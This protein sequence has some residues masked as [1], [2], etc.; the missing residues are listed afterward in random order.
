MILSKIRTF[1]PMKKL[2]IGIQSFQELI[3][4]GH[5]YVDKTALLNDLVN[6]GKYY[7]LSRPRRFGK[8]LLLNTLK[9]L[10]QGKKSLFSGLWIEDKWDWEQTNPVLHFSFDAIAYE[11]MGLE[12][13][14]LFELKELANLYEIELPTDALKVQFKSLIQ[15]LHAK[16]GKVVLLIDEYDKPIIDFLEK[17]TLEIAKINRE[18]LRSFYAVLKSSDD[19]LRLVFITGIS[20]FSQVSIF[21]NLNNLNDITLNKRYAT[22]TGYT[23]KELERYFEDHLQAV[24]TSLSASRQQILDGL[25]EWYNGY[26]WDGVQRV[27]NPFG[28]LRFF[29]DERFTN[30]WFSTG[31]P[32]FLIDQM[33]KGEFF[34]IE[35]IHAN[36]TTF[37]RFDIENLDLTSLLF[38]TGY[39]TVKEL[40]LWSGDMVLDYPNKEVRQ[41]MYQF[42]I[43]DLSNNI[44]RTDT[45][46]T[47]RNLKQAF[48]QSDLSQVRE[49]LNGLL[50]DLPSE[51]FDKKS[52]GL[53]HGLLHLVFKYLGM[54]AQSEVHSSLGR[55]DAVVQTANCIYIF[56]FKFNKSAA[57]GLAQIR[58]KGYADKYR[59]AGKKLMGIGVN[60]S[61]D[62]RSIDEWVE[63]A[64]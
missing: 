47:I 46:L 63:E 42:L 53:Y 24:Q 52:E 18:V 50:A 55:A 34:W 2:P 15:Q 58:E 51:V 20:K 27:Y 37:E 36:N 30:F 3:E 31:N 48:E 43:D 16:Y 17:Q 62:A 6:D 56:E 13:A 41:S 28:V 10:F 22:L 5:T 40:D 25:R 38:Q 49:I 8:S 7:F 4:G 32:K 44:Q 64:V 39:L 21:S 45:G 14:L 1:K 9:S 11:K 54:Y 12:E 35:N 26:S 29:S 59:N 61:T 19:Y 60:F 33:R 57:E 23:Q